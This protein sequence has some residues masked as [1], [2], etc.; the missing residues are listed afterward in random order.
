MIVYHYTT[1]E[2]Y[3]E[4]IRSGNFQPSNPWTIMDSAH[5]SGW[6]FTDLELEKCE[7]YVMYV[8][9]RNVYVEERISYYLKYEIDESILTTCREH[10]YIISNWYDNLIKYIGG[11]QNKPCGS[12]PCRTCE[13]RESI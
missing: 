12:K 10:V 3:D 4:I 8:C 13:K 9:W 5:G 2:S 11:G 7:M 6:Y 1:K